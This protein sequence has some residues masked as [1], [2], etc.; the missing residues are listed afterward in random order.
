VSLR[1]RWWDWTA[2]L[3][4]WA[5]KWFSWR[6]RWCVDWREAVWFSQKAVDCHRAGYRRRIRAGLADGYSIDQLRDELR[7]QGWAA[8][9]VER[10]T[11]GF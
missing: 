10:M 7:R 6:A 3:A 4:R 8:A 2:T 9:D 11:E 5:G 1:A